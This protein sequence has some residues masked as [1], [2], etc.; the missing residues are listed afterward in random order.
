VLLGLCGALALV[1][2]LGLFIEV[3]NPDAPWVKVLFDQ[4]LA[5][6]RHWMGVDYGEALQ[7]YWDE[8]DQLARVAGV[9]PL[10]AF[11]GELRRGAARFE[12]TQALETVEALLRAQPEPELAQALEALR[13]RMQLAQERGARFC[14]VSCSGWSG[15]VQSNLQLYWR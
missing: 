7:L 10:S 8:L 2:A 5:V 1:V 3:L 15:A 4:P 12:P 13:A 11:A 14:M 9:R 6:P